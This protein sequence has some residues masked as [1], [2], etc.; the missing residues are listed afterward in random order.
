[1]EFLQRFHLPVIFLL[2][3]IHLWVPKGKSLWKPTRLLQITIAKVI[4]R[5]RN[6]HLHYIFCSLAAAPIWHSLLKCGQAIFEKLQLEDTGLNNAIEKIPMP[7]NQLSVILVGYKEETNTE[8]RTYSHTQHCHSSSAEPNTQIEN[9]QGISNADVYPLA[10]R[11]CGNPV[12]YMTPEE[13]Y[14]QRCENTLNYTR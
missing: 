1:M 9:S 11:G 14:D 2:V 12:N 5:W 13:E 10:G 8:A 7:L 4:T 6:G 3:F